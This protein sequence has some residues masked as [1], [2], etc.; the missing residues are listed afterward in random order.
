MARAAAEHQTPVS[1]QTYLKGTDYPAGKEELLRKAHDNGAPEEVI[2]ILEQ[3]PQQEF[4][5][6]DDVMK[7]YGQLK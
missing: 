5:G 6:P 7:A 2:E 3:L 4:R 1:V